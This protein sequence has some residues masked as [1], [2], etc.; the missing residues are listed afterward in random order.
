VVRLI[1]KKHVGEKPHF[2]WSGVGDEPLEFALQF[3]PAVTSHQFADSLRLDGG[4]ALAPVM[5]PHREKILF[6]CRGKVLHIPLNRVVDG[7]SV[8]VTDS[9]LASAP[10]N[11]G[12][13]RDEKFVEAVI[14]CA[15]L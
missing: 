2:F 9:A 15:R 7:V 4:R 8:I 12:D 14:I 5:P 10:G 11:M 3:V 6:P 1:I 13:C